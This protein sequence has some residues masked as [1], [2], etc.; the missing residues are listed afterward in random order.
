MLTQNFTMIY[1]GDQS[2]ARLVDGD[3]IS[4]HI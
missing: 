4:D 1:I 2:D 3:Q